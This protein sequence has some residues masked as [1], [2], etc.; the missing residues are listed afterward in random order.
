M[1]LDA[2]HLTYLFDTL[3]KSLCVRYYY[4][5][6]VVFILGSVTPCSV[7]IGGVTVLARTIK[8]SVYIRVT[9]PTLNR[10]VGKYN[11]HHL[12]DRVLF[13]TPDLKINNDNGHVHRTSFS[14]HAHSNQ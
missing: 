9:N 14:G 10:S 7:S 5:P 2:I 11:L 13:N 12:R 4:M 3:S 1:G 6:L 8:E